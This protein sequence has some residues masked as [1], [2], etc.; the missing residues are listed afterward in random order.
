MEGPEV[1]PAD[2]DRR[3]DEPHGGEGSASIGSPDYAPT[4]PAASRAGEEIHGRED[5]LPR[6]VGRQRDEPDSSDARRSSDAPASSSWVEGERGSSSRRR[7][8]AVERCL[9]VVIEIHNDFMKKAWS[10][11][12]SKLYSRH[13]SADA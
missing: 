5:L 12:E 13:C 7:I 6:G 11:A 4:S 10:I 9:V 2:D 3:V 1:V 8:G